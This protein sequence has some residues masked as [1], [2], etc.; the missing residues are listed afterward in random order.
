MPS[1]LDRY[2]RRG[3]RRVQG[4]LRPEV[5]PVLAQL[6]DIQQRNAVAGGVAE[7]GVHH[8]KLFIALLLL[9]RP[10]ERAVAVDVFGEQHLNR[11]HSG[12]GDE[13]R[14]R[15]NVDLHASLEGV[16]IRREDSTLTTAASI[17]AAAGPMRLFSVDGGHTLDVVGHDLATAAGSLAPGGVVI[18]DDVFNEAWPAVGE[19]LH[20]FLDGSDALVPFG[21]GFNKTFLTTDARWAETYRVAL[22]GL[23]V[24]QRWITSHAELHGAAVVSLLT[25]TLELRLRNAVK[26]RVPPGIRRRAGWNEPY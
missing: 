13:R 16:E 14:F 5:F 24:T 26:R 25:P 2:A 8:G 19:A 21:I 7:I 20:R 18:V 4:W 3:H 23:A 1:G 15:R 22:A 6:D 9:R 10:G 12:R 11:D 17:T